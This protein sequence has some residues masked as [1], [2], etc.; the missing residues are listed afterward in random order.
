[1]TL[2]KCL[3]LGLQKAGLSQSSSTFQD[4][5]RD[6]FNI[7]IKEVATMHDWRW[8]YKEA[9]ISAGSS[10]N[11]YDLA[12]GVLKPLAFRTTTNNY[13]LKIV[14]N[15]EIDWND[16]DENETGNSDF[17]AAARWNTTSG[18]WEVRF[19]PA[20]SANDTIKYRYVAYLTDF[21][22][23]NDSSQ[24]DVLGIPDWIA[25]AM[26]HYIASKLQ[27]VYGD[28]EGQAQDDQIFRQMITNH[29]LSDSEIDGIDGHKTRLRRRDRFGTTFDFNAQQGS[30]A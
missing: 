13:V 8:L 27:G 18:V 14:D 23:A 4:T 12:D 1:M 7:G 15:F 9:T 21:T 5:A 28:F 16:P 3:Q 17:V 11:D 22:S 6:Y 25:T 10:T 29:I 24:T 20:P 30:L 26:V 2:L 19:Y